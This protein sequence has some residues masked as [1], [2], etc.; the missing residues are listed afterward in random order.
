MTESPILKLPAGFSKRTHGGKMIVILP[1]SNIGKFYLTL[2]NAQNSAF[3]I[4]A[5]LP[6]PKRNGAQD[7]APVAT[8]FQFG[9]RDVVSRL[10]VQKSITS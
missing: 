2:I 5:E 6:L 9:S 3:S 7:A 10:K 8:S 4:G 1:A